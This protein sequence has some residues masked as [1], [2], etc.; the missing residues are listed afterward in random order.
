MKLLKTKDKSTVKRI[1]AACSVFILGISAGAQSELTLPFMNNLFQS[2]YL[3]PVVRS[4]HAISIGLPVLSSSYFQ[5]IHNGFVPR[6]FMEIDGR[7]LTISPESLEKQVRNRNM[8]H[9]NAGFD[10]FHLKMRIDNWDFWYSWRVNSDVSF[11]YPKSLISLAIEGNTQYA[12]DAMDLTPFGWNGS[13]YKEHS[14]GAATEYGRWVF[15]GRASL[16]FGLTNAY[17]KP[18]L[19]EIGVVD[20]MYALSASS[21]ATLRTS[22]IPGDSFENVNFDQFSDINNTLNYFT[23]L[24]NPGFA[25]S[26][27]ASYDYDDRTKFT[28]AFSN[29]GLVSWSDSTKIFSL[30]GETEFSGF[31]IFSDLLAGNEIEA[32][33]LLQDFLDN[34]DAEEQ[35]DMRYRTWLAPRFYLAANYRLASRTHVGVQFYSVINRGYY[36][37]VSAGIT[38]GLGRTLNVALS[39][40]ANQRTVSNIGFGLIIKPGPFQIYMLAD[41]IYS[42]LV[43]PLT[44]TNFNLRLGMNLVFGRVNTIQGLPY[45]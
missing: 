30:K 36:P 14:F 15:G 7:T 26:G 3:N 45:R 40:S 44:F 29:L 22:G 35:A 21:D 20:E 33:T 42:P 27:G 19:F 31:D 41:N 18:D 16:L 9:A 1:I 2:T 6:S 12:G 11:F 39:I 34:F 23:R 8:L 38:Q 37:A 43:D 13:L 5:V 25:L 24:K 4:E 10:L 17:L 32:D 28:F